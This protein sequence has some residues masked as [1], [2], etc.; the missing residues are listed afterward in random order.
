[1]AQLGA[2]AA[3]EQE[4]RRAARLVE[5]Y[6]SHGTG[7]FWQTDRTGNLTYLTDKVATELKALGVTALG[8]RLVNIFRV[9]SEM[10]D[11]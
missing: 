2:R 5:E 6:E 7:W 10:A 3:Q 8:E 1:H 9:D 11:T 4:R